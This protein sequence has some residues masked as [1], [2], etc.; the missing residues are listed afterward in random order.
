M[1]VEYNLVWNH[2]RDFK[3]GQARSASFIWN[4]KYDFQPKI[5]LLSFQLP[6]YYSHYEIA[7]FSKYLYFIAPVA[8]LLKSGIGNGFTS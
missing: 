1:W 3:I 7:K 4:H 2:W 5:A 6:L 8:G